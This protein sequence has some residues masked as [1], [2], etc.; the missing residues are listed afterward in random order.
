MGVIPCA[1]SDLSEQKSKCGILMGLPQNMD[2]RSQ[3]FCNS[4]HCTVTICIETLSIIL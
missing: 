1:N 3:M 2:L 4:A